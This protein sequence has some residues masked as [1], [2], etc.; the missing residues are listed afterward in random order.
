VE[1]LAESGLAAT[2]PA[3]ERVVV[4]VKHCQNFKDADSQPKAGTDGGF[5]YAPDPPESKAGPEPGGGLK[6]YGGMTY[7][8]FKSFL[9]ARMSR[10]DPRVRAA[11][12]WIRAH[13]NV[14]E[15]PELGMQGLYYYYVTMAKALSLY[16]ERVIVDTK[17]VRH[18][19]RQELGQQIASLQKEDGSWANS[20]DRWEEGDPVLVTAYALLAMEYCVSP[21]K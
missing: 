18:D 1:A 15:N 7:A 8:G 12:D 10:D 4:F 3:Y 13:F 19:W 11:W 17:G 6:S 2:D 5:F 9:H 20:A 21:Q 14:K 16:G